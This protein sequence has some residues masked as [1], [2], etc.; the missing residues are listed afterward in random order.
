LYDLENG[1]TFAS[2]GKHLPEGVELRIV[3]QAGGN[4]KCSTGAI[5]LRGDIV[6]KRYYNNDLATHACMTSDGWFDTGDLG[7]ADQWGN[8]SIVGRTKEI[9][10]INGNNYSSFELEHAIESSSIPGLTVSYTVAFST[11]DDASNS[12][13]VIILFLP[14]PELSGS[15]EMQNTVSQIERA[16]IK[17]CSKR[18]QAVLP[19]PKEKMPKSTIGKLSRSKLK[20]QYENGGFVHHLLSK[21]DSQANGHGANG[22]ANGM[23]IGH[24]KEGIDNESL[25]GPPLE[26]QVQNTIAEVVSKETGVPKELMGREYTLSH[27]GIDSLGY[28]RIKSSLESAFALEDPVPMPMLLQAATIAEL[29]QGLLSIGTVPQ[30]YDPVV[31]LSTKGSK[32][33][34]WLFHPGSG[35]VLCWLPILKYLPDRPLYA[36]RAKGLHRGDGAFDTLEEMLE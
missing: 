30:T 4:Q 29:E 17:F 33:P 18:P 5:Q 24:S 36:I 2:V 28:M 3:D 9:I 25:R 22:I 35:E 16:V 7:T 31:P 20:Q 34:L 27:A 14:S 11:W 10:I 15:A 26:T 8:L 23:T 1:N 32:T 19:L 6:F 12:E 21:S 13:S